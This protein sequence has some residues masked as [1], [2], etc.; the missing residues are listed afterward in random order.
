M[1]APAKQTLRTS[2]AGAAEETGLASLNRQWAVLLTTYRADGR[3]VAT[4]V[5]IVVDANRAFFRTYH[6]SGKARRLGRDPRV[7]IAPSSWNGR[8]T[9]PALPGQARLLAG[10]NAERAGRLIDQKYP[11][12]QRLLVRF[13]HRLMRYQT[14]HFEVRLRR[15]E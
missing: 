8:P 6:R 15:P 10:D 7:Q 3:P 2:A 1:S 14:L 9:G 5:S 12:F 4:P 13:G 11:F